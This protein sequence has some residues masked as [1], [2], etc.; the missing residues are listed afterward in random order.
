MRL[1]TLHVDGLDELY[2][3]MSQ[4]QKT[5]DA[6]TKTL[7]Y[8]KSEKLKLDLTINPRL[9]TSSENTTANQN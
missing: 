7:A 1:N 8:M 3:L 6:L 9:D 5:Y 4:F 2:E